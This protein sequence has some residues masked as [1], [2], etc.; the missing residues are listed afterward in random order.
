M[1]ATRPTATWLAT[2]HFA[3]GMAYVVVTVIS[4]LMFSQLGLGVAL[5]VGLVALCHLPWVLKCW[6]KP[7][8]AAA[9]DWRR[10][11]LLTQL[12]LAAS[13]V[14][15]AFAFPSVWQLFALLMLTAFL[16]A[17]HNVAADALSAHGDDQGHHRLMRELSR[18]FASVVGQGVLVMMAGNLQ[19]FFRNDVRFSWQ[20]VFFLVAA[21]FLLLFVWH[22]YRLPSAVASGAEVAA[23]SAVPATGGVWRLVAYLFFYAFA[24]GMQAKVSVL[25][26][27]TPLRGGG[28]GLSPQEFGLVMGTLGIIGLTAGGLLGTLAIR[29]F[30]WHRCQWPMAAAMLVPGAVYLLL[31]LRQPGGLHVVCLSVVA[32]QTAFGFGFAAYLWLLRHI[33]WREY[34]KSLMA[35]SLLLSGV[36]A[37]ALQEAVGYANFFALTFALGAL[38]LLS[39][40]LLR[41]IPTKK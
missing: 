20:L 8:V 31:S 10:W 16:T 35:L 36:C 3:K 5:T 9:L 40:G 19:V 37:G 38:T 34:G 30:G 4:L 13:F 7:R 1:S 2:L 27:M 39:A 17:I 32:E 6:W 29:R 24:Q 22:A 41:K 25:F 23:P 18:K 14:A 15:M 33:A 26:L 12:L 28:L 11:V 21:L